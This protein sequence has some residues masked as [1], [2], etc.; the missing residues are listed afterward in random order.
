[1]Q[2]PSLDY[3]T[4]FLASGLVAATLLALHTIQA[5]KLYPGFIRIVAA[6]DLLTAAIIAA[7]VRGYVSDALWAIQAT[8]VLAFAWIDSGIRLF[9]ASPRRGRWPAVYVVAAVLLQSFL[10]LTSQPLH[11][12]I[13]CN[14]LLLMPIFFDA[15]LPFLCRPPRGCEFG[16]R[17]TGAV[18]IFG[19]VAASVRMAAI[20]YL[21]E[22]P[23]PYFSTHPANTLF[24]FLIMLLLLALAFG[25]IALTHERLVAELEFTDER[26]RLLFEN[27]PLGIVLFDKNGYLTSA[28]RK[29]AEISGYSPEEAVGFTTNDLATLDD[30]AT[31]KEFMEKLLSGKIESGQRER[32]LLRKD[33]STIWVRKTAEI[34]HDSLGKPQGIV[35][36]EDIT[37]RMK[38]EDALRQSEERFRLLFENAPLGIVFMDQSG[39][40]TS[41]NPMFAGISGYSQEESVGLSA[42]DISTPGDRAA[43]KELEEGILS[44]RLKITDR[45]RPFLRKDGSTIWVRLTATVI[46]DG[47][48]KAQWGI[49][50]FQDVTERLH[51]EQALREAEERSRLLSEHLLLALEAS[52]SGTFEWRIKENVHIWGPTVEKLYGF[53][54][55]TF[56]GTY[57]A[58]RERLHPEDV[59]RVEEDVKRSLITGLYRDEFHMRRKND[60]QTRWIFSNAKVHFDQEGEPERMVGINVD[61]TERKEDEEKIRISEQRYRSLVEASSQ[62]VWTLDADGQL[63]HENQ[64]WLRFTGQSWEEARGLGW[65][66]AIHPEDRARQVA[67][68]HRAVE[69]KSFFALEYRLKNKDGM[70]RYMHVRTVPVLNNDGHLIEW[71]EMHVDVTEQRLA[72]ERLR[73]DEKL[74]VA[75]RLGLNISHEIN[76]PLEAVTNFVYLI[77]SDSG[78]SEPTRKFVEGAERELARVS[79]AVARNLRFAHASG[80]SRDA[81]LR[82][83]TNSVIEFFQTRFETDHIS[84]ERDYRTDARLRCNPAGLQVVISNL[85]G[86][87]YDAMR[88]GGKLKIRIREARLWNS[89]DIRGLKFSIADTGTGIPLDLK[90]KIFEPFFTTKEETGAGLGL[91]TCNEIVRK[92]QGQIKF[93]TSI[94]PRHSGTVFNLFF[95]FRRSPARLQGTNKELTRSA[96]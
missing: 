72:E 6:I 49:A 46:R 35:V 19:C 63:R 22:H 30:R 2:P 64:D 87:A 41:A 25:F 74:A 39:Q 77:G 53:E 69:T 13:I 66:D 89:P 17:F 14:S 71:V 61:I 51:A 75:G 28:N 85:V 20:Y 58:W 91:W 43:A 67:A 33:G 70:Y 44:G 27:A 15:S 36:F 54:P 47:L 11:V 73:K 16:Y 84:V 82:E 29:F 88:K 1:M 9:C 79:Q 3:H 8:S 59:S 60:G 62:L 96:A 65:S 40:I 76:N 31:S 26:F 21:R 12:R 94:T 24:F 90:H 37:E 80:P 45:D 81:D 78:L 32:R 50:V 5:R 56:P 23:S 68:W 4:L 7:D 93:W 52:Q 83:L 34:M 92:H 42:T 10:F 48:G 55:G 38:A 18:L 95:P 86:N 57:E